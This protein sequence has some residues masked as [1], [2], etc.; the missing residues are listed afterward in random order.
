MKI[1]AGLRSRGTGESDPEEARVLELDPAELSGVFRVP[2]WLRDIGFTAWLL[3]GALVLIGAL[4]WLASLTQVIVIPVLVGAIVATVFSPAVAFLHRRGVPRGLGSV[5][6]ML[7]IMLLGAG[8]A[9]LLVGGIVGQFGNIESELKGAKETIAGWISDLGLNSGDS[10]AVTDKLAEGSS[11]SV[12]TLLSGVISGLRGLSS[13]VFF[14]AMTALSTFFLLKDGPVIRT[15]VERQIPLPQTVS[16]VISAR[17]I[18]SLR[19]Y[20]LGVTLV[21]A[22]TTV[23]V[24]IGGLII[25]VPYLGAIIAITFVGGF[26]PYLGAWGA[27]AFAVLITLGADGTSAALAMV[28]VQLLANGM[29]QQ[30]VQPFAMGA[31]L[32]IHPL[33]VLVVTIA[34]GALFGAMGLIL[35]APLVAAAAGVSKDLARARDAA[36]ERDAS[37]EPG[38]P[39]EAGTVNP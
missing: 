29:L 16:G 30:L 5:L 27:G 20:F 13:L 33:A 28:V 34:G 18:S 6:I 19:G 14:L 31:T 25:G 8:V 24:A 35:A 2:V 7:A 4:V 38:P 39:T 9:A 21:S 15:W 36:A 26:V 17:T 10:V 32:G 23:V 37:P 22:F 3:V 12:S 11:S 1:R